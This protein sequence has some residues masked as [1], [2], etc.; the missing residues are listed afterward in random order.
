MAW[1]TPNHS[2]GHSGERIQLYGKE[3]GRQEHLAR[4]SVYPCQDCRLAEGQQTAKTRQWPDLIGTPKQIAWANDIRSSLPADA[5]TSDIQEII[6]TKTTA[7]WWIDNRSTINQIVRRSER[8][9]LGV[10]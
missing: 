4:L 6:D 7:S 2:C 9:L 3:S 8:Q 10:A 1:Y 5:I